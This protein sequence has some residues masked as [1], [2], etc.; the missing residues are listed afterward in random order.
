[1]EWIK[2]TYEGEGDTLTAICQIKRFNDPEVK[3]ASFSTADAKAAG[4]LGKQGPW[5]QYRARMLK[6]RARSW[7]L[8]DGFSDVL[9]GLG[10]T[11]EVQDIPQAPEATSH[12][13]VGS[14]PLTG[15]G[16]PVA[17]LKMPSVKAADEQPQAT[18][19]TVDPG[20]GVVFTDW[21]V[22]VH[23]APDPSKGGQMKYAV[24]TKTL[25]AKKLLGTYDE[26]MVAAALQAKESGVAVEVEYS[27]AE[28]EKAKP[29]LESIVVMPA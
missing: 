8:R 15:A 5:T 25:G 26:E 13:V 6:M 22:N 18:E 23:S 3:R 12:T 1:M 9:K 27:L 10:V 29:V 17:E 24:Q 28:G 14:E 21:V 20:P 16:A 11:E 7:A 4:L 19:A 2:E